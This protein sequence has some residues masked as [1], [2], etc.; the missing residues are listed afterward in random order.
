MKTSIKTGV[1]ALMLLLAS[2]CIKNNS[3]TA[4][5]ANTSE[6]LSTGVIIAG[7]PAI[8][9]GTQVWMKRDLIT[10]YY[11]NGDKIPEVKDP[12]KWAKLTTG[13]WCWYKNDPRYGKLYNWYAVKDPRGLAPAGWHVPSNEEWITLTNNLGGAT[14]AGGKMKETGTVHWQSPNADA[15]NS[16]GF[17]ALPG[18]TRYYLG[19]FVDVGGYG[20]WWSA[21]E[22]YTNAAYYRYLTYFYGTISGTTDYKNNG[23]SVRCVK[24]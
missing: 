21:T 19:E 11:R 9:I 22:W 3:L 18:G 24:D 15:T 13:A 12:A 10:S 8:Q 1:A 5:S 4:L 17:T 7:T 6:S 23:F 16:S 14:V 2:S 20:Y